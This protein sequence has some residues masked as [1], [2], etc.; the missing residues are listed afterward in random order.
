MAED[1]LKKI[2]VLVFEA[3]KN[4]LREGYKFSK[5]T[6]YQLN[7]EDVYPNYIKD[8]VMRGE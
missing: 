8:R 5:E 7:E 3:E 4:A 6:K 2:N 1:I